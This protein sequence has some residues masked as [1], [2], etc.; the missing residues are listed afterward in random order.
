[1]LNILPISSPLA[2]VADFVLVVSLFCISFLILNF[3]RLTNAFPVLLSLILTS[4]GLLLGMMSLDIFPGT[5]GFENM[6]LY[7]AIFGAIAQFTMAGALFMGIAGGF[8][9]FI[10]TLLLGFICCPIVWLRCVFNVVL[11]V[12]NRPLAGC[13]TAFI[14]CGLAFLLSYSS[15]TIR[16]NND[17]YRFEVIINKYY[18]LQDIRNINRINKTP[19]CYAITAECENTGEVVFLAVNH[20]YSTNELTHCCPATLEQCNNIYTTL[21]KDQVQQLQL[22]QSTHTPVMQLTPSKDKHGCMVQALNNTN[23]LVN[24]GQSCE[25]PVAIRPGMILAIPVGIG[26][27]HNLRILSLEYLDAEGRSCSQGPNL[28]N[29][30]LAPRKKF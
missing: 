5:H 22:P 13:I 11:I 10:L 27:F 2:P 15:V 25:N 16:E 26:S 24:G 4:A 18:Y 8:Y 23:V 21:T 12:F 19:V 14:W 7:M 17:I 3:N 9:G 28:L 20:P 30:L 29:K 6:L 1:M